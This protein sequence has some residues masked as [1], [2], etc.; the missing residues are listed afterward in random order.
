MK[1]GNEAVDWLCENGVKGKKIT[2][3]QAVGVGQMLLQAGVFAHVTGEHAFKDKPLLYR[4][5]RVSCQFFFFLFQKKKKT[6]SMMNN[7]KQK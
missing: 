2:R 6:N 1:I 4:F 7:Q 5:A 3:F